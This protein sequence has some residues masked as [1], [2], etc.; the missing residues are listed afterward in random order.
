MSNPHVLYVLL[1]AIVSKFSVFECAMAVV[2]LC[3]ECPA[4]VG[5]RKVLL[6]FCECRVLRFC[7]LS[8]D[9]RLCFVGI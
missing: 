1:L 6:L 8:T 2:V 5:T 3:G 4:C 9:V 7:D